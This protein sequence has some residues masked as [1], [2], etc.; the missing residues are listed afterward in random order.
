MNNSIVLK[1][2]RFFAHHGVLSQEKIIG[3]SFVVSLKIDCDFMVAASTDN[4]KDTIDYGEIFSIVKEEMNVRSKLMEHL[5][6][7]IVS[8]L[9]MRFPMINKIV[10][11]V[12]KENPP[13]NS[14]CE[15]CGV[16]LA[17]SRAEFENIL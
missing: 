9:F 1:N 8:S 7:R 5:A 16:E 10:V 15:G 11:S 2:L 6:Q 3:H 12:L 17:L 13:I 14:E 4:V